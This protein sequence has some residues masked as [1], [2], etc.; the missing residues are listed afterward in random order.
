MKNS[1]CIVIP[2][3]NEIPKEYEKV[4]LN[5]LNNVIKNKN[6]NIF[7]IIPHGM[8]ISNYKQYT[9]IKS[10]IDENPFYFKNTSAY[11]QLLLSHF[12]YIGFADYAMMYIF[13]S[14]VY[15]FK[16]EFQKYADTNFDYIGAPI[17]GYGSDWTHVPQIGN[18][19]FSLRKIST[20]IDLTKPETLQA[21]GISDNDIISQ[22]YEDLFICDTLKFKYELSMPTV[23]DALKFAWDRNSR[24]IYNNVTKELPM[25]AHWYK[26]QIE[27]WSTIIPELKN[28]NTL[29][30]E[31]INL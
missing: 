11:S 27:F 6:Y 24:E 30:A 4:A 1:F 9:Y 18:G 10:F 19:G 28:N 16:D 21:L 5:Q 25:A 23:S 2:L 13:Q 31:C 17:I 14:G 20:F 26:H 22:K 29:I 8:D 15:I 7:A 12:L 3:Y